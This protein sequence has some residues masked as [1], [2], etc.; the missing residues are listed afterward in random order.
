ME[1][2]VSRRED[3]IA[4]L[5]RLLPAPVWKDLPADRARSLRELL[6]QE[7]RSRPPGRLTG[8][9]GRSGR[10]PAWLVPV[11]AACAV[12]LAVGLAVV[13]GSHVHRGRHTG[14]ANGGRA[15]TAYVFN[16][17]QGTVTP[18]SP[19]T[20][21]LGKPV[22][23]GPR[24]YWIGKG[25]RRVQDSN[26]VQDLILPGGTT[27]YALYYLGHGT[28]ATEALRATSL[29]T[30]A[31]GQPIQVGRG[32][33]R[34]VIT[35]DGT[36]AYVTYLRGAYQTNYTL[37][38]VSLATGKVGRPILRA[39]EA[40]KVSAV[41]PSMTPDGRTLYV[42]YWHQGKVTPI[43]TATNTPGRPIPVPGTLSVEFTPS[44]RTAFVIGPGTVTP[45]STATNTPGRTVSLGPHAEI[46]AFTPDGKTVYAVSSAATSVTPISTRTG[47]AGKPIA[48]PGVHG[49]CG[50]AITPDG[51]TLYLGSFHASRVTPISLATNTAGKP[52][53]VPGAPLNIV[54]TPDGQTAYAF[55]AM[56]GPEQVVT[57]ISTATNTVGKPIRI[58]GQGIGVLVPGEQNPY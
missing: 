47:R 27:N 19:V 15:Q 37:R 5:A 13:L 55:S 26:I 18:I 22:S 16:P 51:R 28:G 54:I 44:G 52:L 23:V 43:S 3:Q 34:M 48:L 46:W 31:A 49:V 14:Q 33:Q 35:P 7:F 38:P 53:H 24:G 30:G 56:V 21:M 39:N 42:P 32:A 12:T 10:Q 17:D 36:T 41:A 29:V 50:M 1:N 2:N 8:H 20:G 57:P 40:D 6:M 25:K 11:A 58:T 9:P 45:I 4:E